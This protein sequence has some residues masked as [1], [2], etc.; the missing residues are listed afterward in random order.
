MVVHERE[1]IEIAP[2]WYEL[3]EKN[4]DEGDEIQKSFQGKLDGDKG[5]LCLSNKKLLFVHEEGFLSKTYDLI[6]D[7]P[8]EKIDNISHDSKYNLEITE[9]EGKKHQFKSLDIPVSIIEKD[10]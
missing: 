1:E 3:A 5:Y 6:L 10:L 7:L 2:K 8:K 9:T 4:L